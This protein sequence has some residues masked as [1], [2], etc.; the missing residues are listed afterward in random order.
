[1]ITS[2]S[3]FLEICTQCRRKLEEESL[4]VTPTSESADPSDV[5]TEKGVSAEDTAQVCNITSE[6]AHS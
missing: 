5:E 4:V 1:M 3:Y 2:A 6:V